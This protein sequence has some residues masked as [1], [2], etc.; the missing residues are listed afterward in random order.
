MNDLN[1]LKALEGTIFDKDNIVCVMIDKND[2]VMIS[3]S[4][5]TSNFE[6]YGT[7]NLYNCYYDNQD[8]NIYNIWVDDDN[9]IVDVN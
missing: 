8:S 7:C 3:D 9:I 1:N 6:G 2:A 5:I 4:Y